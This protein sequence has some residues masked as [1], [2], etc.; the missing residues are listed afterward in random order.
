MDASGTIVTSGDLEGVVDFGAG[1]LTSV[2]DGDVFV[3]A[4]DASGG[5]LWSKRF[6]GHEYA[7]IDAMA[8]DP[9]GNIVLSGTFDEG[10]HFGGGP[11]TNPEPPNVRANYLARFSPSGAHLYSRVAFAATFMIDVTGLATDEAG[12]AYVAGYLSS[13]LNVGCSPPAGEDG[14]FLAKLDPAGACVYT[15]M[16]DEVYAGGAG[17]AVDALGN[18]VLGLQTSREI[19]LGG[20]PI[21][22]GSGVR[23]RAGFGEIRSLRRAGLE[24]ELR[25][26]V[27]PCTARN[28][29][30][31]RRQ[32]SDLDGGRDF[33]TI[34]FGG[35][36]ISDDSAFIFIATFAP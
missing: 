21:A 1:P 7:S 29:P 32:R 30:I 18:V 31:D 25:Q 23:L 22:T 26:H 20:G 6:G 33:G 34:D 36:Q 5:T 17:V 35:G 19:D 11:L 9:A 3:A 27:R 24:P 14:I 2:G 28:A 10:I 16:F 12:N 4:F 15:R 8:V 13:S